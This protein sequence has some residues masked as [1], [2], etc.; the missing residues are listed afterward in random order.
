MEAPP[1]SQENN[2]ATT[3]DEAGLIAAPEV[4]DSVEIN[5]DGEKYKVPPK[6]KDAFFA[7][8]DYTT[9]TQELAE[10]RRAFEAQQQEFTARQ[11]YQQKHIE[12]VSEVK[13]IDRE[14]AKYQ[15]LDWNALTDADPVQALK[16]DR[17]MRELQEQRTQI[18]G[19]IQQADIQE[20]QKYAQETTRRRSEAQQMLARDIPGYGTPETAKA[21]MEVGKSFGYSPEELE[22]VTD[23]R[24]VKILHEAHLYRQLSAKMKAEAGKP[25]PEFKPI[26]RVTPGNGA[27]KKSLAEM[28]QTEFNKRRAE[29]IR[30]RH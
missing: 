9:K 14:L 24:A 4:D 16:L 29:Q 28:S 17:Q 20:Q 26:T 13:A 12:A 6:L 7:Q 30:A 10:Q 3:N 23:A 2:S 21:L 8:K 11:Q 25:Q 5:H 22:N 1:T 15:K 18:V 19:G 27:G